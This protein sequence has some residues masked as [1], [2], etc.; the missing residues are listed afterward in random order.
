MPETAEPIVAGTG[1][2]QSQIEQIYAGDDEQLKYAV[3]L[4]LTDEY[5]KFVPRPDNIAEWDQQ[6]G[7]VNSPEETG[8]EGAG[9][10]NI[11]LGGNGS[12]KTQAA[13]YKTARYL[14]ERRPPREECP[15]WVIGKTFELACGVCWGEKLK[16]Y[17][18]ESLIHGISWFKSARGWPAAVNLKHP[19]DPSKIGWV[20]EFKSYDQGREAMQARSIGGYWFNEE[21]P[22]SIVEEVQAR[23]RDYGSPGWA[24]F[25]PLNIKSPEWRDKYDDPPNGWHFYHLNT[26]CNTNRPKGWY[27]WFL[28]SVAADMRDTRQYGHFT[29]LS[30]QVFKDWR[31]LTHVIPKRKIPRDWKKL[32]GID[33]GHNNPT[34]CLW[35]ARQGSGFDSVYYVYDEHYE[36]RQ[37]HDYHAK[38]IKSRPW[39]HGNDPNYGPTYG[40]HDPQEIAEYAHRG[41]FITPANKA[42]IPGIECLQSLMIPNPITGKPRLYV[43]D[44]C[45]NLIKEIG[46]YRYLDQRRTEGNKRNAAELPAEC[47][48]HAIDALRYA[49]YSDE[50]RGMRGTAEGRR[51]IK[52]RNNQAMPAPMSMNSNRRNSYGNLLN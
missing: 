19:D 35:I 23:C 41:I 15:F 49:I 26:L 10:F 21:V 5:F 32:R 13:A 24:D 14:R 43:M 31:K 17:I 3:S 1:L 29:A 22:F 47:D 12:G 9:N 16:H 20:I 6:E 39:D 46:K 44:H 27:E 42:I 45:E 30:G 52:T 48:D 33:Y 2:T 4:L 18:P 36:P 40:D 8:K 51:L 38:R 28:G 7:F 11:C 37:L 50:M 25:T 34:A